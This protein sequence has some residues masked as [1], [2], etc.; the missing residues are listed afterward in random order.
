MF[1]FL[2]LGLFD[3]ISGCLLYAATYNA[4]T[5]EYDGWLKNNDILV[6]ERHSRSTDSGTLWFNCIDGYY[7]WISADN[8]VLAFANNNVDLHL[9][10]QYNTQVS[11]LDHVQFNYGGRYGCDPL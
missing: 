1:G 6:C 5:K 9:S 11:G 10:P 3:L 8:N 7:A 2:T 4:D